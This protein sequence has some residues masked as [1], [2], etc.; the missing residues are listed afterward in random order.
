MGCVWIERKFG[1][2][3]DYKFPIMS[4][5]GDVLQHI[6]DYPEFK[7][8]EKNGYTVID[9]VFMDEESFNH[10][11]RRECR[12]LVFDRAG[13]LISRPFHKF[14]N[15]GERPETQ[16]HV[17]DFST[18]HV[19]KVKADGSMIR[20]V[21][22]GDEM[23]FMTRKGITDVALQAWNE[24]E[25]KGTSSKDYMYSWLKDGYTPLYEFVSPRNKIVIEYDEPRLILLGVRNNYTGEYLP[26]DHAD[27]E[28]DLS[29]ET[30][31]DLQKHVAALTDKIE[32]YVV[33]F[34][35]GHMLK[36]KTEEYLR[37]HRVLDVFESEKHV[38]QLILKNETDDLYPNLEPPKA[39]KLREFENQVLR[40]IKRQAIMIRTGVDVHKNVSQKDFAIWVQENISKLYQPLWFQF[41]AGKSMDQELLIDY[42][43]KH[44]GTQTKIEQVRDII[45]KSWEDHC[46][47][48]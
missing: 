30:P 27:T 8:I 6:V 1:G 35:N 45:G 14:F 38:L 7:V 41:R 3:M 10:P 44:T 17:V 42:V 5:I 20:P 26:V 13:K 15:L 12:G 28:T 43:L 18:P 9:Y 47:G 16:P 29:F 24:C 25:F 22:L 37:L 32:G 48:S 36:I 31:H 39:N 23:V 46:Y 4:D 34:E 33:Q 2:L 11:I 21:L 19:I 40:N